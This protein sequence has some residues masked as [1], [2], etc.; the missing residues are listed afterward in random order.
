MA[1]RCVYTDL[2]GTLL[3]RGSSLF[4]D[5]EGGFSLA[6]SRGLEACHRAGVEVVIVSGLSGAGRSTAAKCLED[7]GY[8]VVD[9]LPPELIVTLVELGTRSKGAVTR[10]AVVLDVRSRAFPG[11]ENVYAMKKQG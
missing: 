3:G 11:K 4:R 8:F 5:A 10:L 1:L 6:Q 9:N 2:D 7:L